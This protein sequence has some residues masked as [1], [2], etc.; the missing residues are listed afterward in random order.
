VTYWSKVFSS[1][2][3]RRLVGVY[4]LKFPDSNRLVLA[5]GDDNPATAKLGGFDG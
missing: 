4:G 2:N 1:A 3:V 5:A